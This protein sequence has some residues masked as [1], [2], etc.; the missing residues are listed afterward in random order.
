MEHGLGLATKTFLLRVVAALA[1]SI[2]RRLASLVLGYF[3]NGVL[4]ALL[5]LA[6][7]AALLRYVDHFSLLTPKVD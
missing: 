7:S 5:T 1:L 6:E 4:V 2:V 3:V